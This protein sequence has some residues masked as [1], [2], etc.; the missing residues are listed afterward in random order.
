MASKAV[1]VIIKN[2]TSHFFDS[3]SFGIESGEWTRDLSPPPYLAAGSMQKPSF[4]AWRLEDSGTPKGWCYYNADGASADQKRRFGVGFWTHGC[5]PGF[6]GDV[7]L[8]FL[9]AIVTDEDC[10]TIL[11]TI[12]DK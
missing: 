4:I 5:S 2:T 7:S 9:P 12:V 8:K 1:T 10:C 3:P 6:E 11:L